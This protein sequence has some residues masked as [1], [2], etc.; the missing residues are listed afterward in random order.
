MALTQVDQGLLSSTAQYTGFKNRIINGAMMI[1]Q[2]NAGASVTASADGYCL[3]RWKTYLSGGGV[4]TAQQVSTAPAGF[5]NSA[6]FT[7]TTADSSIAAG[8]VYG[9]QQMVEGLNCADLGWGTAN[10]QTI[11]ISFWV[12]S[13]VTGTYTVSVRNS[14]DARSYLATYTVNAANTFE[15]KT[16]TIAGDTTGTWLTTNGVGV[17]L[18][19]DLGAGSTFTGSTG[20]WSAGTLTHAT[21]STNWIATSGATFYITG[22]QLEK[23]ST[24]TSFDYRPYGTELALCQRYFETWENAGGSGY[25]GYTPAALGAAQSTSQSNHAY[26]FKVLKRAVPTMTYSALG[27]LTVLYNGGSS[28]STLTVLGQ[29]YANLNCSQLQATVSGTPFVSYQFSYLAAYSNTSTAKISWSSEL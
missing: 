20:A 3:D 1:D 2:R 11:T 5:I 24:A 14:S 28:A 16:I 17:R 4:M 22:V 29:L 18:W 26:F 15:Q 7:V 9:V 8:D 21:G 19:F 25:G 27:D 12:R 10:A 23:G 13:S 6:L